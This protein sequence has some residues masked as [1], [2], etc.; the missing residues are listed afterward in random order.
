MILGGIIARK[1]NTVPD[2]NQENMPTI[3]PPHAMIL[4]HRRNN[5][6][7]LTTPCPF[8]RAFEL[9]INKVEG[10]LR[11]SLGLVT[12]DD[13]SAPIHPGYYFEFMPIKKLK[14][15]IW[16]YILFKLTNEPCAHE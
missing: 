11:K 6:T 5:S 10:L 16:M 9:G 1:D 12:H 14:Q 7:Q 13:I 2:F 4:N 3:I 15:R 8:D